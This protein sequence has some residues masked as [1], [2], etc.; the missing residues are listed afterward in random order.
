MGETT[1][2]L[3]VSLMVAILLLGKFNGWS[4]IGLVPTIS[5]DSDSLD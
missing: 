3:Q 5:S 4:M 2:F 1:A